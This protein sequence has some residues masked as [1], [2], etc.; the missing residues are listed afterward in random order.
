MK[1][2][3]LIL[4]AFVLLACQNSSEK[5]T[6]IFDL[7][8]KLTEVSGIV[9]SENDNL[10]WVLEDSGNPSV[11][12]GLDT[13]E[14]K[15]QRKLAI[16]DARNGDWED[17]TKD[18]AGNL[19]IGDFGNNA[20]K[21][22]DL[23]IYKIDKNALTKGETTPAYKVSFSYP[24]QKEFP[25]KKSGLFF[26]AESF[27]EY[28]GNF[29]LFTKNRSKGY[30]GTVFVYKIPNVAGTHKASL[31]G[32]FKTCDNFRHCVI[33]SAAISPDATKIVFLAHDKVFLFEN[34]KEGD[35]LNGTQSEFKLNNFS[36]K[37]AICFIDNKTLIIAEEKGNLSKANVYEITL[38]KLKSVP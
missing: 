14:G 22:K 15:I 33:T 26:D 5:L 17:I 11:I 36:Q 32:K 1:N 24:E 34:Y 31:V 37:E 27:F 30:D 20:N 35:F 10:F 3:I 19:Y 29:Y 16:T 9:Y 7:P 4:V 28:K 8:K 21:R 12:Y 6:K 2:Y 23:C 25:P 38:D 18:E 13:Q